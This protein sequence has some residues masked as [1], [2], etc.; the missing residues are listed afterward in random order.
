VATPYCPAGERGILKRSIPEGERRS[1]RLQAVNIVSF[2]ISIEFKHLDITKIFV[3]RNH[4]QARRSPEWSYL[5]EA[6]KKEIEGIITV[7]CIRVESIPKGATVIDP[8]WVNY[9]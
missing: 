5:E 9:I 2:D 6:E 3:P 7:G 4:R 1:T 8:K